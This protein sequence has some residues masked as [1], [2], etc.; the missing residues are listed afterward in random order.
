[1]NA[2][3]ATASPAARE[4]SVVTKATNL[5]V[6]QGAEVRRRRS[7]N[8]GR[9]ARGQSPDR[10]NFAQQHDDNA[11]PPLPSSIKVVPLKMMM[12]VQRL[13]RMSL[14]IPWW[15]AAVVL[16]ILCAVAAHLLVECDCAA[17]VGGVAASFTTCIL[18]LVY[19]YW[20]VHSVIVNDP[21]ATLQLP[22]AARRLSLSRSGGT[23]YL[24]LP[25]ES[26]S[27][28]HQV[29]T[30][31]FFH[32]QALSFRNRLLQHAAELQ[33][34]NCPDDLW[35]V[36]QWAADQARRDPVF[37]LDLLIEHVKSKFNV[38]W[39]RGSGPHDAGTASNFMCLAGFEYA[40]PRSR[41][42]SLCSCLYFDFV[43]YFVL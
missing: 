32:S 19:V 27:L 37:S 8:L 23:F 42:F 3:A 36:A 33:F 24:A 22:S 10:F 25:R 34:S 43:S 30:A 39:R 28:S 1:M 20:P 35:D 9:A 2:T 11:V 31:D 12:N 13:W 26:A 7:V 14:P 16:V 21:W 40:H 17:L 6:S 15:V 41:M 38:E 5:V 29:I 4:Q 18:Y